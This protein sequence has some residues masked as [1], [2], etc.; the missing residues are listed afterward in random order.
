MSRMTDEEVLAE[1]QSESTLNAARR[2]F[3]SYSG[4]IDQ[5]AAGPIE[6]RRLEFEAVEAI[7]KTYQGSRQ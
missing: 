7:V 4:R 3:S 6:M 1:L 5:C 2:L